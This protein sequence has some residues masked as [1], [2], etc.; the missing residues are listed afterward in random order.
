MVSDALFIY[1]GVGSSQTKSTLRVVTSQGLVS[2]YGTTGPAR[3]VMHH[4]Q[5]MVHDTA[6]QPT[7]AVFVNANR[8]MRHVWMASHCS[9]TVP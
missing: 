9:V 8:H 2:R 3:L 1:S 4:L 5:A 7:V 6:F